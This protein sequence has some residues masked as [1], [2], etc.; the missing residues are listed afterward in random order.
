MIFHDLSRLNVGVPTH[1]FSGMFK[2]L[3]CLDATVDLR[4]NKDR[5]ICVVPLKMPI[6]GFLFCDDVAV[7][8]KNV[9]LEFWFDIFKHQTCFSQTLL[10]T[11]NKSSHLPP[12]LCCNL[13]QMCVSHKSSQSLCRHACLFKH[14]LTHLRV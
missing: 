8:T 9:Q 13:N 4:G 3:E 6:R 7:S 11:R 14:P 2:Y 5:N 12:F 10:T 1:N